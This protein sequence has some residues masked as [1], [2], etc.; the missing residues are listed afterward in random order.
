MPA[1]HPRRTVAAVLAATTLGE[2][3]AALNGLGRAER[4]AV[5][6]DVRKGNPD[7]ADAI[8]RDA[9]LAGA[10]PVRYPTRGR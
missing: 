7:L 8:V 1:A 10:G 5:A 4:L 3:L 6:D 2:A 9:V